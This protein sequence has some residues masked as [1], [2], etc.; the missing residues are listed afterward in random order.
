MGPLSSSSL[1]YTTLISDLR[2][3]DTHRLRP[4]AGARLCINIILDHFTPPDCVSVEFLFFFLP[5]FIRAYVYVYDTTNGMAC[6][7]NTRVMHSRA[8]FVTTNSK[9]IRKKEKKTLSTCARRA[10]E[11]IINK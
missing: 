6:Y 9:C 2:I 8:A 7:N 11:N 5:R 3:R 10:K 4:P 1:L